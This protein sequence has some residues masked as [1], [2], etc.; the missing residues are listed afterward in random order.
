M[1]LHIGYTIIA[2]FANWPELY[3]NNCWLKNSCG[4]PRGGWSNLGKIIAQF[5]KKE[6]NLNQSQLTLLQLYGC[7]LFCAG[8]GVFASADASAL[9]NFYNL[10]RPD[11]SLKL[12]YSSECFIFVNPND[13]TW[14]FWGPALNGYSSSSRLL[15]F[16]GRGR[17]YPTMS[18]ADMFP[19]LFELEVSQLKAYSNSEKI[20]IRSRSKISSNLNEKLIC[21]KVAVSPFSVSY[22]LLSITG[23]ITLLFA[24]VWPSTR[25]LTTRVNNK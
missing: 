17:S 16:S 24:R 11:N 6:G 9:L 12:S 3:V 1:D 22:L 21:C 5:I 4:F 18:L 7:Y 20:T 15:K 14:R 10:V 8:L 2:A 23:L 19:G 13:S 25:H